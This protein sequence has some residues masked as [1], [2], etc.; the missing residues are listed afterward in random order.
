MSG[1]LSSG[2]IH[3]SALGLAA[4]LTRTASL[5]ARA[6]RRRALRKDNGWRSARLLWP[7]FTQTSHTGD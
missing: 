2:T 6:N 7:R 3:A 5:L 1:L 4:R